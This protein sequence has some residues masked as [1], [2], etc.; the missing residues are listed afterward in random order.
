MQT[1]AVFLLH[2]SRWY[3]S[4]L[5]S[6]STCFWCF[7]NDVIKLNIISRI[8]F[9]WYYCLPGVTNTLAMLRNRIMK[10]IN[11]LSFYKTLTRITDSYYTNHN[12]KAP[13]VN[14]IATQCCIVDLA[15]TNQQCWKFP[16]T[17]IKSHEYVDDVNTKFVNPLK[18][19][20]NF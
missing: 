17:W 14:K 11:L 13:C 7:I 4:I 3:C 15:S 2:T 6:S 18:R 16:A 5:G 10:V 8:T 19:T 9:R 20:Q 12:P 1:I